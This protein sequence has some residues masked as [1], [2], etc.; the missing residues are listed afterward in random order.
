M[1]GFYN[2]EKRKSIN[3]I[4]DKVMKE[5]LVENNIFIRNGNE[6]HLTECIR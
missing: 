5:Y 4:L 3:I 6:V 2:R 1:D